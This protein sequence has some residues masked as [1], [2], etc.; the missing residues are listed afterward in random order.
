ML[1]IVRACA[2]MGLDGFL[3][4]VQNDFNPRAG[5]PQ[6]IVVGLPD[7]AVKE[8]RERVRSA[9]RNSGLQFPNKQY[10]VNLSPADLPKHSTSYDLAIAVSVLAATDQVPLPPLEKA[11][12]VGELSLDG[13]VRHVNGALSMAYA[14]KQA[15][16]DAIYLSEAD[17]PLSGSPHRLRMPVKFPTSIT[18][19]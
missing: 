5:I 13:T 17:A 9:I 7:A 1:S 19:L 16:F 4:E 6:F 18:V 12:F 14:A 11:L 10:T 2:I 8:S 15:G 3:I